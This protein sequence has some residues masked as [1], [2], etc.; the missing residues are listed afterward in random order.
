[1][2]FSSLNGIY[3]RSN[4]NLSTACIGG[5]FLA[6]QKKIK[7]LP[8]STTE[9]LEHMFGTT[10]SWKREFTVN[11]FIIFFNKLEIILNNLIEQGIYTGTSSK[12]YMSGFTGFAEVLRKFL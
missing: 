3:S 7:N 5:V 12:G 4:N 9:P 2:W 11:E 8:A 1:M 6:M 10:G